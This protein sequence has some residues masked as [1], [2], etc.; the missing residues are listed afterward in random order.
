MN[1]DKDLESS[2]KG[3]LKHLTSMFPQDIHAS[4]VEAPFT[5]IVELPFFTPE[6]SRREQ[7]PKYIKV[8]ALQHGFNLI[9]IHFKD[10]HMILWLE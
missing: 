3:F 2:L 5:I 10:N 6:P 9:D 8:I 7:F 4:S 1:P